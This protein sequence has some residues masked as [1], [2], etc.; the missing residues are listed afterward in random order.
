[1]DWSLLGFRGL[2]QV[3]NIHPVFVHFPIALFPTALLFYAIGVLGRK[4][5]FLF[6]AQI[7]L[8]LAFLS[9]IVTVITGLLA[10]ESFPHNET[11][12]NMMM[13]H[14]KVGYTILVFGGILFVWSFFK[15]EET[16]K[17]PKL[18]LAL[19]AFTVLMVLQN[20]DLGG[21]MVFVEGA[22]VRNATPL[23]E[24]NHHHHHH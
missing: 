17:L 12:H 10:L 4:D 2:G 3:F 9:V 19:L 7:S 11:I 22:A 18:F 21:R 6:A 20:G 8:G 15:K 23:M 16:P 5:R 14:Q 13:T 1:M 24:E